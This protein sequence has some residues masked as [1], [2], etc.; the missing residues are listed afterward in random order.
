MPETTHNVQLVTKNHW[1]R[2][3]IPKG[4]DARTPDKF[5][6]ITLL[7]IIYKVYERLFL[8]ILLENGLEDQLHILQGG[9][10][11]QRGV[12]EQL[13]ILR[14]VS[15]QLVKTKRPLFA[16]NLDIRK[17]YDTVWR[18]A[19]I[20]KLRQ[21]FDVPVHI[22]RMLKNMLSV[23][24]SGLRSRY[25]ITNIFDTSS[26]VVQGSVL[27]PILYAVCINDLITQLDSSAW[28][29][30]Y[31]GSIFQPCYVVMMLYC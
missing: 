3:S 10:R 18:D 14:L 19:I 16:V 12:L 9:F 27:S 7:P 5:R 11:S 17:A 22:L 6:P 2:Q 25:S 30:H 24:R 4:A 20:Y 15:E 31:L 8:D 1:K 23:T 26:G 29:S 21:Q 13:G 28:G